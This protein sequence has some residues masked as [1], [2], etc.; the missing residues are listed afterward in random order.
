MPA[1]MV[2][3]GDVFPAI[4][5]VVEQGR[6]H[7]DFSGTAAR[8]VDLKTQF[9]D[10]QG[11]GHSSISRFAHPRGT[12]WTL[13]LDHMIGA[14]QAAATA[15]IVMAQMMQPKGDVNAER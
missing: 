3:I 12:L 1:L 13:P 9:P 5:V 11:C 10:C 4:S 8:H 7:H 6:R 2:E 14:A 15:K